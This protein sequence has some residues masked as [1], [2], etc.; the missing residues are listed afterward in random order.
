MPVELLRAVV[1][2]VRGREV[3]L[4]VGRRQAGPG[5]DER[6]RLGDG[7]RQRAAAAQQPLRQVARVLRVDERVGLDL[8]DDGDERVVLQVLADPARVDLDVDAE[9]AQLLGGPDPG[10]QQQ[11]R[12][13]E[14]AGGED[15]LARGLR[16]ALAPEAVPVGDARGP[17]AGQLHA[18]HGGAGDDL[19]VAAV[20]HRAQVGVVGAPALAVALRD[21]AQRRSV[22]L[23]A[24]VVVDVADAVGLGGGE[25][26][27]GERPR[28][29]LVLHAQRPARG[30]VLGGAARVV[31]G[32]EE[33]RAHVVPAPAR[34]VP[35]VVVDRA[36]AHVEHRVHAA[37]AAQALAA[38]QIQRAAVAVRLGLGRVVPVQAGVELLGEGGRD[39]DVRVHAAPARLQQQHARARVL[40]QAVG[41]HAAGGAGTDDHVVRRGHAAQPTARRHLGQPSLNGSRVAPPSSTHT[42]L[43]S[44]YSWSASS[45]FSRPIPLALKPPKG[46]IGPTA[47]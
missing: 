9:R 1:D 44:V 5:A 46:A 43:C 21:L 4:D 31:L 24:V 15:H 12:G 47:R 38:R 7:R 40:R 23:R 29:A 32:L 28:R 2:E 11:L 8:A 10:E 45:P 25:E 16:D 20:A 37:G 18:L 19:E 27:A 14:R 39:R 30:V 6:E 33:V 34:H 36:P 17:P 3:V 42:V 22:L 41:E 26:A 35:E 13:A